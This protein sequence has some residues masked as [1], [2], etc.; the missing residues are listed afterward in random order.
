MTAPLYTRDILRLAAAI[1]H[2]VG[3][4]EIAEGVELRSQACGTRTK[5][6]VALDRDGRVAFLAQAVEACAFGQAASALMAAGAVG[7]DAGE[8]RSAVGGID[9]WLAGDEA[10]PWPGFVVLDPVR[11]RPGRHGAVRLP[12]QA[13]LAAI[14]AAR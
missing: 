8:V 3:F 4:D 9:R 6:R 7:R 10:E 14:E 2:Q 12:F 1:P 11:S 13:L 5:V